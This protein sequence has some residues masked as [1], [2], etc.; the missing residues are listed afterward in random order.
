MTTPVIEVDGGFIPDLHSRYFTADF[1]Y[2][3]TIIKQIAEFAGVNIPNIDET[4]AWY[5]EIAVVSDEFRFQDYEI[6][7]I[8][9]FKEFYMM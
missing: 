1:S 2:G 4:M 7:D 3:L 9:T 8:D 5:K 6:K